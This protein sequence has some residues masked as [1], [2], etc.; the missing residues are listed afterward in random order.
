MV[1]AVP[2]PHIERWQ[3]LDGA[4]FR[5][6]LGKGCQAPEQ[7]CSR[8]LYKQ[9][10]IDAIRAARVAPIH[11]GIEFAQDIVSAMEF[12]RAKRADRSLRLFLDDLESQFRQWGA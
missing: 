6:A 11:G 8:D 5:Q 7:K 12:G 2:D 4:A 10:L 1:A 3:L 9:R